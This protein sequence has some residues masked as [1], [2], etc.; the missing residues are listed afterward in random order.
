MYLTKPNPSFRKHSGKEEN[1]AS[2]ELISLTV[3]IT[4]TSSFLFIC[5]DLSLNS[6]ALYR[7]LPLADTVS[8]CYTFK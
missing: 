7:P 3:A 1:F 8:C 4:T 6:G 5:L 2:G